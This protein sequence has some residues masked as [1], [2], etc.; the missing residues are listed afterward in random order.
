MENL[1]EQF[2]KDKKLFES[3][4]QEAICPTCGHKTHDVSSKPAQYTPKSP[5]SNKYEQIKF[6]I[7]KLIGKR[8]DIQEKNK[9]GF[10]K[11]KWFW[12]PKGFEGKVAKLLKK[13]PKELIKANKTGFDN[14]NKEIGYPHGPIPALIVHI[15]DSLRNEEI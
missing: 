8:P 7:N 3:N 10:T 11:L 9:S 2:K 6:E 15:S 13:Y 4:I 1:T 12:P 5:A 14:K